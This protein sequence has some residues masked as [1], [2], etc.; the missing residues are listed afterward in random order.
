M[1][2]TLDGIQVKHYPVTMGQVLNYTE[3][4]FTGK[5]SRIKGCSFNVRFPDI[6]NI[7]MIL[8]LSSSSL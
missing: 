4:F 2:I 1:L 6:F 5:I 7:L 8:M 3:Q